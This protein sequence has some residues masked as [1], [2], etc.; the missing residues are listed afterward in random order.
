MRQGVTHAKVTLHQ[1]G[2]HARQRDE[3][4]CHTLLHVECASALSFDHTQRKFLELCVKHW[5]VLCG[6]E[7]VTCAR[8]VCLGFVGFICVVPCCS[9]LVLGSGQR[10]T[11]TFEKHNA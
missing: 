10:H 8:G 4:M 3:A 5:R 9:V 1:D 11:Q 7:V 6:L 2:F